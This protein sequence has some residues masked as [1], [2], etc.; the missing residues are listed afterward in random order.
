MIS[1]EDASPPECDVRAFRGRMLK[2]S[3]GNIEALARGWTVD[4][5]EVARVTG[6]F[7][8]RCWR[9]FE[10]EDERCST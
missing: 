8:G 7:L 5:I 2:A 6:Q 4:E 10:L 3:V 1:L 9:K